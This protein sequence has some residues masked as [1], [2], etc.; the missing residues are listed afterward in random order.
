[1]DSKGRP[2][3]IKELGV[4]NG[5]LS[6]YPEQK[7]E[8]CGHGFYKSRERPISLESR[9]RILSKKRRGP[10]PIYI[11][12]QA[13]GNKMGF[14]EQGPNT[15]FS[16]S[17]SASSTFTPSTPTGRRTGLLEL[18][19]STQKRKMEALQVESASK[20]QK[21][22][23]TIEALHQ[24][25]DKL[26]S[27]RKRLFD[28]NME[29]RR[30]LEEQS[31]E[32]ARETAE[33]SKA[34]EKQS[35][36]S[37]DSQSEVSVLKGQVSKL[38]HLLQQEQAKY[39][40]ETENARIQIQSLQESNASLETL[41][42]ERDEM[43]KTSSNSLTMT[44]DLNPELRE[45]LKE[46]AKNSQV[47]SYK[48]KR[49]LKEVQE[50]RLAQSDKL[51]LEDTVKKQSIKLELLEASEQRCHQ[52]ELELERARKSTAGGAQLQETR[53]TME[54]LREEFEALNDSNSALLDKLS[55]LE[56]ERMQWQKTQNTLLDRIAELEKVNQ[57]LESL[58]Q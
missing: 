38:T 22:A 29:L 52:L 21:H 34:V 40:S 10:R 8:I 50:L 36:R 15:P 11:S 41:L 45:L 46:A 32:F 53:E 30:T 6:R 19:N 27:D 5:T 31:G 43:I 39:A 13:Q 1:M 18:Q 24:R 56:R 33:Y 14:P 7:K 26:E 35:Q 44:E 37:Q 28:E 17:R 12:C 3:H 55:T 42:S 23:V 16:L 57:T 51:S 25:I 48:Y 58:T 4:R 2:A 9:L 20:L 49:L 54:T 47:I